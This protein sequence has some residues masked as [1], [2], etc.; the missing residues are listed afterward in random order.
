[1]AGHSKWANTKFRKERM[2]AKKSKIFSRL[3]KEIAVAARIDGSDP[4]RNPRLRLALSKAKE[5]NLPA[6]NI[7]RAI[8]RGT[9]EIE[10]VSYEEIRYEGYGPYGTAFIIECTTDNRNRCVAEVRKT[11]TKYGG[12]L[13]AAGAVLFNFEHCGLFLFPEEI[14][15]ESVTALG[16]EHDALDVDIA[17]DGSIEVKT[18]PDQFMAFKQALKDSGLEPGFAELT[19][20]PVNEVN[21]AEDRQAKIS[22][23]VDDL[24]ILD[25]TDQV[26]VNAAIG[27]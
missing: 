16:A 24:E 1:M 3:A 14:D 17:A 21:L 8:K 27:P 19:M 23:M 20:L 10:G 15:A 4:D 7:E 2:D 13:A 11:F 9:G 6:S 26:Y 5:S 18:R 25:D 12:S 22:R